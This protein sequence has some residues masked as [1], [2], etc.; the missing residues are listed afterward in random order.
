MSPRT[1]SDAAIRRYTPKYCRDCATTIPRR[2]RLCDRCR[3]SSADKKQKR[4]LARIAKRE[5]AKR[6]A[7]DRALPGGWEDLFR[8]A[9][10]EVLFEHD[11]TLSQVVGRQRAHQMHGEEYA[12][13]TIKNLS[14]RLWLH[15]IMLSDV[16][17]RA[18]AKWR[19]DQ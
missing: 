2:R 19:D 9:L 1:I 18:E 16:M 7:I 15:G 11:K 10:C 13:P 14:P 12:V 17:A 8:D 3:D 5:A 4:R 6:A